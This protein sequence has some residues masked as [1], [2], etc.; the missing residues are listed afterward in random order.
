MIVFSV[1]DGRN[2]YYIARLPIQLSNLNRLRSRVS[3]SRSVEPGR[4]ERSARDA[5]LDPRTPGTPI[6]PRRHVLALSRA[7]AGISRGGAPPYGHRFPTS[8]ARAP[9]IAR[10]RRGHIN[11]ISLSPRAL[12]TLSLPTFPAQQL[13]LDKESF[14]LEELLEEDDVIQECKSLNSRL[15][16]L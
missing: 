4:A 7:R 10:S 14:T 2:C 3:R 12:T 8:H 16:D 1:S 9:P 13:V 11:A 5:W 6:G 15:I